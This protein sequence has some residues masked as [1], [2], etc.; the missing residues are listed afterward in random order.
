MNGLFHS[1]SIHQNVDQ[2]IRLR[3]VSDVI[4]GDQVLKPDHKKAVGSFM[5]GRDVF[6]SLKTNSG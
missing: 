6:E 3:Y 4:H 5:N 2:P 1:C